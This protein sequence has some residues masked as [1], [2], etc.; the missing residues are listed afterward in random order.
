MTESRK[1]STV[2]GAPRAAEPGGVAFVVTESRK[3]STVAGAPRAAE[4]G[5]VAP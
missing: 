1:F 2:A 5:G 4:P 3:F